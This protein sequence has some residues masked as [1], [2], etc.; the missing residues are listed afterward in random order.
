MN[1]KLLYLFKRN[2][3][4]SVLIFLENVDFL[5]KFSTEDYIIYQSGEFNS[6]CIKKEIILLNEYSVLIEIQSKGKY[7]NYCENVINLVITILQTSNSIVDIIETI[8]RQWKIINFHTQINQKI[9]FFSTIE[10]TCNFI[11]N[12]LISIISVK[13]A[14]VLIEQNNQF[15]I[16]ASIGLPEHIVKLKY[17]NISGISGWV[18][19]EGQALVIN[20]DKDLPEDLKEQLITIASKNHSFNKN[21]VS[22]PIAI[23]PLEIQG[24]I[25]GVL[26]LTNKVDETPFS[27]EDLKII[28][29]IATEVSIFIKTVSL[30]EEVKQN[31]KLKLEMSLAEEIQ[32][33]I[34]PTVFPKFGN[35]S[36]YG[37]SVAANKVGGDYF[38]YFVNK[39][40]FYITIG[41]VSGHSFSSA[42]LVNNFRSYLKSFAQKED[43]LKKLVEMINNFICEDVTDSGR[44]ITVVIIAIDINTGEMS[45]INAGH[46]PPF[47]IK[48]NGETEKLEISGMPLGF[49]ENNEYDLFKTKLNN[50]DYIVLYTDG[51]EESQNEIGNFFGFDNIIKTLKDY[52]SENIK[53][54]IEELFNKIK[55]F[56]NN[57]QDDLTAVGVKYVEQ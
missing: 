29:S 27:S 22:E 6:S 32:K 47:I 52:N 50:G 9:G 49:F 8:A 11:L 5:F 39:N 41:D 30:I 46:N 37:K 54:N 57:I 12:L 42:L 53:D 16:A 10:E 15:L 38:G 7:L 1:K 23:V 40:M 35:V 2:E 45:Y 13:R 24:K 3:V 48:Q 55:A 25:L 26:N 18:F 36:F 31:E 44:F 17:L 33:S 21:F 43:D 4:K 28:T 19:K 34:L 14:S 51:F 20:S 56:S